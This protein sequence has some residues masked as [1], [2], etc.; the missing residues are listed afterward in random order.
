MKLDYPKHLSPAA[1]R[2]WFSVREAVDLTPH[3]MLLL[4]LT[5]ECLDRLQEAR[6][7]IAEHGMTYSDRFGN[8]R[9]RPEVTV[10]RDCRLAFGKLIR[11]LTLPYN[12]VGGFV[13]EVETGE[14]WGDEKEGEDN[15]ETQ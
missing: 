5:C 10:E 15:H 1:G 13:R 9:L 2:F 7:A 8:P 14:P 4:N 6:V 12:K 11:Q 3:E